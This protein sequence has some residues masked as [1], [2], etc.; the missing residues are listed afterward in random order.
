MITYAAQKQSPKLYSFVG[1]ISRLLVRVVKTRLTSI[2]GT[3]LT[4]AL[5]SRRK[6]TAY[7]SLW[8]VVRAAFP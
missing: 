7:F 2:G 4:V 6:G 8:K 3:P 5:V 1:Y